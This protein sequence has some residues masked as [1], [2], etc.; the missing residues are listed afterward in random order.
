VGV[1]LAGGALA[2]TVAVG[3]A[4]AAGQAGETRPVFHRVHEVQIGETLWSIARD[5]VGPEGDPRPVIDE[6][7][8]A[9]D[10]TAARILP[11]QRLSVPAP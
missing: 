5:L 9:N 11:G 1:L 6:L 4:G 2:A 3:Q 7:I 8:A 10:L